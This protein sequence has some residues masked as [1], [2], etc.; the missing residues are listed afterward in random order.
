MRPL[1]IRHTY[2]PFSVFRLYYTDFMDHE[3]YDYRDPVHIKSKLFR[4]ESGPLACLLCLTVTGDS[5]NYYMCLQ[6]ALQMQNVQLLANPG[7]HRRLKGL[8]YFVTT[9]ERTR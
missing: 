8:S 1:L 9:R 4:F 3:R 6:F 7:I 2:R 5:H